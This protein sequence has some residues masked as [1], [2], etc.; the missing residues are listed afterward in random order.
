MDQLLYDT[1]LETPAVVTHVGNRVYSSNSVGVG[2]NPEHPDFPWIAINELPTTPWQQVRETGNPTSHVFAV[3][4]YDE[5]GD[6]TKINQIL[7]GI[8]DQIKL[9]SGVTSASG[10]RCTDASYEGNS[11]LI[12]D[13]E[14]SAN[15]KFCTIRLVANQ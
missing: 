3:Y 9:L 12:P 5:L 1:I 15:V 4:V 7:N 2:T 6:G 8:R 13:R 10:L 11:A 14:Y